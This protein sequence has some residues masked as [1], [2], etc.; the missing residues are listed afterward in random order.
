MCI[1]SKEF[2]SKIS[3]CNIEG[4]LKKKKCLKNFVTLKGRRKARRLSQSGGCSLLAYGEA[5]EGACHVAPWCCHCGVTGP[6]GQ[7]PDACPL[8]AALLVKS[9]NRRGQSQVPDAFGP[10]LSCASASLPAQPPR[11]RAQGFPEAVTSAPSLS[12]PVG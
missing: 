6:F 1:C 11:V 5:R 8:V 4:Y 3:F 2:C 12:D 9:P 10:G 7:A